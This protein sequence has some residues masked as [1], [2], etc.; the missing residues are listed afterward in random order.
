MA[1]VKP[2]K[3]YSRANKKTKNSADTALFDLK[4]NKQHRAIKKRKK[5][6]K[7]LHLSSQHSS[8]LWNNS[9]NVTVNDTFDKLVKGEVFR[10]VVLKENVSYYKSDSDASKPNVS[11]PAVCVRTKQKK[12][13]KQVRRKTIDTSNAQQTIEKSVGRNLLDESVH[14][15]LEVQKC[16]I[17]S[18]LR[19]NTMTSV[20][21]NNCLS[22]EQN[23][24]IVSPKICST[25]IVQAPKKFY[26]QKLLMVP[27]VRLDRA[28]N[29]RLDILGISS[30]NFSKSEIFEHT[31]A[32][33]HST[34]LKNDEKD[35]SHSTPVSYVNKRRRGRPPRALQL[36]VKTDDSVK[37]D[38]VSE[39]LTDSSK[40]ERKNE[41]QDIYITLRSRYLVRQ[42]YSRSKVNNKR[43]SKVE[44]EDSMTNG[45]C[46]NKRQSGEQEQSITNNCSD[47][48]QSAE[49]E[50]SIT[51]NCLDKRES[52]VQNEHSISDMFASSDIS[53]SKS[54]QSLEIISVASTP[55]KTPK[56]LSF[57]TDIKKEPEETPI[58]QEQQ[59]LCAIVEENSPLIND[60]CFIVPDSNT[61][62][63]PRKQLFALKPGKSWRRSLSLLRR[64]S[65]ANIVPR[66]EGEKCLLKEGR[67][68]QKNYFWF[69][70]N[71]L[72]NRRNL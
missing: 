2:T 46:S 56:S 17:S 49:Q 43:R 60:D 19:Y 71:F 45:S 1:P 25:P 7:Q 72:L 54:E 28:F 51:N 34:P 48:R 6:V 21:D 31:N 23:S 33:K 9:V 68:L 15:S 69:V 32:L 65:I 36:S 70:S 16:N 3:T 62:L 59:N 63:P 8:Q 14:T 22:T 67:Y 44:N 5:P 61:K 24:V 12:K 53:N 66:G 18:L 26:D 11:L 55:Q 47:K 52:D 35:I 29:N 30:V 20:H 10:E 27:F 42:T 64:S 13:K 50:Q 40:F 39:L 37:S 58:K 4:L 41:P 57:S 38:D